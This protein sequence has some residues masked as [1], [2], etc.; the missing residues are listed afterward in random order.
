VPASFGGSL[1]VDGA[2][3]TVELADD[4]TADPTEAC[5]ALTGFTPGNI[6]LVDRGTCSFTTKVSNAQD[7]GAVA[8]VVANNSGAPFAMGG[9][10][11]SITVPAAMISQADGATIRNALPAPG[12]LGLLEPQ[13]PPTRVRV[14][15][16]NGGSAEADV[17]EWLETDYK[18]PSNP[19]FTG[20]QD[21]YPDAYELTDIIEQIAAD[22][23]D[24]AEVVDLP[25]KTNG[26]RR[27]AMHLSG[28]GSSQRVGLTSHAWG[29][30]GGND[31]AVAYADPG[32]ADAALTVD[33]DGNDIVVRLATDSAGALVSTA[34][35]VVAAIN[36]GQPA[37]VRVVRR[38]RSIRRP[39]SGG[40]PWTPR[41]T[42]SRAPTGRRSL[43]TPSTAP[44]RPLATASQRA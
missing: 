16:S 28:G 40:S 23:P 37:S 22:F 31:L 9:S 33:V 24:L 4:G 19:Y 34:A 6:A 29:H 12:T 41:A 26:Y 5:S 43:S 1:D 13:P 27:H 3:G 36:G 25:N 8:V 21:H 38:S 35:D 2:D 14:T 42:S 44:P 32:T 18:A 11:P 39:R 7:A 17:S 30:E 20:F 10:D 15:S